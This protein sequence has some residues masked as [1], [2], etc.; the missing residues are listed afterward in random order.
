[1]KQAMIVVN[2]IKRLEKAMEKSKSMYLKNDYAKN[3]KELKSDLKEY[4]GYK[5]LNYYELVRGI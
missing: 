2:E 4:C 3:I 5:K 1:M